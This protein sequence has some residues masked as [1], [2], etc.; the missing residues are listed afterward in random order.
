ML[1]NQE[2]DKE[3]EA[4]VRPTNDN[5]AEQ[6]AELEAAAACRYNFD[7]NLASETRDEWE[8]EPDPESEPEAEALVA[9]ACRSKYTRRCGRR[10]FTTVSTLDFDDLDNDA[11]HESRGGMAGEMDNGTM[12]SGTPCIDPPGGGG[13]SSSSLVAAHPPCGHHLFECNGGEED[14]HC[15]PACSIVTKRNRPNLPVSVAVVVGGGGVSVARNANAH[16]T[17][18][19]LLR[20]E[21]KDVIVTK[22]PNLQWDDVAGLQQAKNSL[23]QA[24][25][26]PRRF[27]HLFT[28]VR[29]PFNGI[30]LY[31]PPGTGKCQLYH[32]FSYST[33][34]LNC[35]C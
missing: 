19:G 8:P 24:V 23:I 15:H 20:E 9:V 12:G 27:P 28:G 26:I 31:G 32:C 6:E 25:I 35:E 29:K 3:V 17:C 33:I 16:A 11:N 5:T 34:E 30:L 1:R 21:L 10:N 13:A 2:E 18:N 14:H 7:Q 4:W 22:K